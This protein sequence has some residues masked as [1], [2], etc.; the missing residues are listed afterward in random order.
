MQHGPLRWPKC[1]HRSSCILSF[2]GWGKGFDL[3]WYALAVGGRC[4]AQERAQVYGP[5]LGEHDSA[6]SDKT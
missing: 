2:Q 4:L 5:D 3:M 1:C 6:A